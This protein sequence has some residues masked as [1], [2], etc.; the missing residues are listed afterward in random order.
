MIIYADDDTTWPPLLRDYLRESMP[1]LTCYLNAEEAI[2]KKA[3]RDP[4]LRIDRP[5][6]RHQ[7]HWDSALRTINEEL[8]GLRLIGYHCSRLTH[9]DIRRIERE[10]LRPLTPELVCARVKDAVKFRQLRAETAREIVMNNCVSQI[11]RRGLCWFLFD[12]SILLDRQA[13]IRLFCSW[14]GEAIYN[15]REQKPSA[16]ELRQV[17]IPAIIS[18][19][20][21]AD[22]ISTSTSVAQR[23]L[24]QYLHSRGVEVADAT[25]WE[26]SV[27]SRVECIEEII[28][29]N[30]K[31]FTDLTQFNK[32]I[33]EIL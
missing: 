28:T 22:T 33:S 3:E 14:G 23:L 18:P 31:T 7:S 13:V 29:I 26:G 30:C 25:P 20:V 19:A 21:P 32:W 4:N 27:A 17:G 15:G 1:K 5:P 2:D 8:V 10:G 16:I 6:N 24:M 11:G 12:R 9:A